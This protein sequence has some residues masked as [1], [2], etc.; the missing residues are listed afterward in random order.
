[1]SQKFVPIPVPHQLRESVI[2]GEGFVQRMRER[3]W[4]V[5]ET[6]PIYTDP[7]VIRQPWLVCPNGAR[8]SDRTFYYFFGDIRF[9]KVLRTVLSCAPC[10]TSAFTALCPN[11]PELNS[12]LT[13]LQDQEFLFNEGK[14]W[15]RGIRLFNVADIGHTLE[16][17][18]AEWFRLTQSSHHLIPARHGVTIHRCLDLGDIDVIALL[19]PWTVTVE[20]KSTSKVSSIELALF[21]K[22]ARLL[23]PAIAVLLIDTP[24][25]SLDERIRRLNELLAD[26]HEDP[27]GAVAEATGIYWGAGHIC[28][29][30][31]SQSLPHSLSS[32]LQ[33]IE[34]KG[35]PSP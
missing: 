17:Y 20:C 29:T 35:F 9:R 21:L 11:V 16:W 33:V 24:S 13:F 31:V 34:Q 30:T 22:R 12:Y 6:R 32:V 26:E 28:V 3:G 7:E 5:A 27:L 2:A 4:S 14:L 10:E 19:D 25:L 18:V 23:W 8:Y 15:R 1:M